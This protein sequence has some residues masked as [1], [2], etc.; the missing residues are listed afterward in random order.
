MQSRAEC[1]WTLA[2]KYLDETALWDIAT[3]LEGDALELAEA[4]LLDGVDSLKQKGRIDEGERLT[5]YQVLGADPNKQRERG[6][7]FP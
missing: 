1:I 6:G 7:R 2:E 4:Y 5:V 3:Y